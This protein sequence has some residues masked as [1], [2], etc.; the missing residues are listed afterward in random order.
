M[1]F[2]PER[3]RTFHFCV[4]YRTLNAIATC[5][6]YSTLL[7][8]K[9]IAS[10]RG[11]TIYS[12]LDATSVYWEVKNAEEDPCKTGFTTH[13]GPLRFTRIPFGLKNHP[14]PFQQAIDA[15]LT[16][17]KCQ[18]ALFLLDD[19]V[20]FSGTLD[21]HFDHVREVLKLLNDGDDKMN[22]NKCEFLRLSLIMLVISFA[23]GGSKYQHGQTTKYADAKTRLQ[24]WS[25]DH[26]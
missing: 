4:D 26:F 2:I 23:L 9:C 21:E 7:M 6:S 3:D 18:F 14:G 22:W 24:S 19:I 10:F 11:A 13:P 5:Q 8:D 20:M 1:V 12:T 17:G 16:K 25:S 15:L